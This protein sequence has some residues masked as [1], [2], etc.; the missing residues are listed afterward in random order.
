MKE[1]CSTIRVWVC[2]K[3]L[4]ASTD[5]F[6]FSVGWASCLLVI[7]DSHLSVVY[8]LAASIHASVFSVGKLLYKCKSLITCLMA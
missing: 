8:V 2:C 7:D 4:A 5:A 3:V 6:V 1:I